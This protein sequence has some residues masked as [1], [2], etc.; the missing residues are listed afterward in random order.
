MSLYVL[1]VPLYVCDDESSLGIE[2]LVQELVDVTHG[3]LV[4]LAGV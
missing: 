4:C 3:S 2:R 1:G